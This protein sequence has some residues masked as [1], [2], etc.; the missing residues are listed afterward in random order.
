MPE[1]GFFICERNHVP[2]PQEPQRSLSMRFLRAARRAAILAADE[3]RR[4]K[5]AQW[6]DQMLATDYASIVASCRKP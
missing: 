2:S 3:E 5:G 6:A 1:D 4:I